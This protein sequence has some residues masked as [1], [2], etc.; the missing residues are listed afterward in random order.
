MEALQDCTR[1]RCLRAR[2]GERL[3]NAEVGDD[4][5]GAGEQDVLRL[6]VAVHHAALVRVGQCARH[7]AQHAD[8]LAHR[9]CA[10]AREPVAQRQPLDE[11][12]GVVRQAGGIAHGDERND[13]RLLERGGELDLSL[14]PFSTDPR[15]ELGAED[16]GDDAPAQLHVLGHEHPRH[17]AATQLA[18]DTV[19]RPEGGLEADAELVN[20]HARDMGWE[21]GEAF[22]AGQPQLERDTTSEPTYYAASSGAIARPL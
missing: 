15:R 13:I 11:G 1:T 18:L 4:R 17:P 3:G 14:E 8:G 9:Q 19:R 2:G 21:N 5:R 10:V 6:D 12:H 16:L 22:Q 7:V 20:G